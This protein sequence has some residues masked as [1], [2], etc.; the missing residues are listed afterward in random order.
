MSL[1]MAYLALFASFS[2]TSGSLL[3]ALAGLVAREEGYVD[4]ARKMHATA[5]FSFLAGCALMYLAEAAIRANYVTS[6]GV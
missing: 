4:E 5:A 2:L 3:L 6:G 1:S